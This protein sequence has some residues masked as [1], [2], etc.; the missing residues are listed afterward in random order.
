MPL[1]LC[2]LKNIPNIINNEIINNPG[3]IIAYFLFGK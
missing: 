3:I 1:S 2:N